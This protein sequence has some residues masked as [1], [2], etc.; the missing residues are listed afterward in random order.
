MNSILFRIFFGIGLVGGIGLALQFRDGRLLFSLFWVFC[1]FLW[2]D[3]RNEKSQRDALTLSTF[4]KARVKA[5][6]FSVA[7]L[8][9]SIWAFIAKLSG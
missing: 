4:F 9:I 5:I 7:M 1:F 3:F 6:F 8:A 2:I